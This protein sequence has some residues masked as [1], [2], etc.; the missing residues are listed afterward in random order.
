MPVIN[1]YGATETAPIATALSP[2]DARRKLGSCGKAALHCELRL[3]DDAGAAVPAGTRGEILVR[4]PNLLQEYWRRPEAT[5]EVLVDGWFHTGDIGHLDDEGFLYIDDR[6]K[7]VII[8][9]GENVYPAEV[10]AVLAGV[11]GIA[12]VAV[13]ARA[14]PRWGEVRWRWW[15][16]VQTPSCAPP[17]SSSSSTA[18]S[19]ATSTRARWCSSISCHAMPWEKSRNSSCAG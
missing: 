17:T 5:R 19:R 7:E 12:E 10:E 8:S 11:P 4:G 16:G 14:H 3:V 13:V 1:I 18:E 9:G 2:D 15:C 6:K